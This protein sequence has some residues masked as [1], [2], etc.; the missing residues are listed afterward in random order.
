[1]RNE[2]ARRSNART[3]FIIR[4]GSTGALLWRKSKGRL[5]ELEE[6]CLAR[7]TATDDE[8]A[9]RNSCQRLAGLWIVK[10]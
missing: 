5:E 10:R 3:G 8:D 6:R 7:A 9:G 1:M 4:F 2:A